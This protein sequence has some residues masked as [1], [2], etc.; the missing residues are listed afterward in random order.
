MRKQVYAF[1]LLFIAVSISFTS[2]VFAQWKP[3]LP[4]VKIPIPDLRT[5]LGVDLAVTNMDITLQNTGLNIPGVEFPVDD[6]RIDIIIKNIG[7]AQLPPN[8]NFSLSLYRNN[9]R[10]RTTTFT[11][12]SSWSY[13]YSD[14][15][16]HGINTVYKAVIT[17][18]ISECLLTNNEVTYP[19][20][21][22]KLHPSGTPDYTVSI[23]NTIKRWQQVGDQFRAYYLLS[24]DVNNVGT[25][26]ALGNSKI[27][28]YSDSANLA[29]A[30]IS[31]DQLPGPGNTRRFDIGVAVSNLPTGTY[32]ARSQIDPVSNETNKNNNKSLNAGQ[33]NNNSPYPQ[34]GEIFSIH[35]DNFRSADKKL[36]ADI[37]V[38][39]KEPQ[40]FQNLRLLLYKNDKL[41]KEW[42][43]LGYGPRASSRALYYEDIQKI[44]LFE[45]NRYKTVLTSD[46]SNA[47]PAASTIL[48]SQDTKCFAVEVRGDMLQQELSD[49]QSGLPAKIRASDPSYRVKGTDV[50]SKITP[51]GIQVWVKGKQILDNW[52]D[53]EFQIYILFYPKA[54]DGKV[55]GDVKKLEVS[56]SQGWADFL[57]TLVAPGIYQGILS[58]IESYVQDTLMSKLP[59]VLSLP[60]QGQYVAAV[61]PFDGSMSVVVWGK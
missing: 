42:K 2:A 53:P 54:E 50:S 22:S 51:E 37:G 12:G 32:L 35:Y 21:E 31:G 4:A 18:D 20:V 57:F 9:E 6:V 23:F 13:T 43:P 61:V 60:T 8:A 27:S 58:G 24:A 55:K 36:A 26:Y 19:I 45:I 11:S 38:T 56:I 52:F 59:S 47:T 25:G 1:I 49:E 7:K 44:N 46:L 29:S 30:N 16:P 34:P 39:N 3:N 14:T 5:C 15:F 10:L 17:A 28:F 41:V 33:I 40:I 48:D